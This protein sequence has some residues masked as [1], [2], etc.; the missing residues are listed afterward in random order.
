[1]SFEIAQDD[2]QVLRNAFDQQQIALYLGAGVSAASGL[3]TWDKLILSV[4]FAA[5]SEQKLGNWRP[6]PN[7]LYAISDWY[8]R[9][10][11]EPLEITARKLRLLFDDDESGQQRFLNA[12]RD[13]LYQIENQEGAAPPDVGSNDTLSAVAEFCAAPR[14]DTSGVK[15]VV[16]Y[17][18]DN[19]LERA[20]KERGVIAQP[21]FT[22]SPAADGKLPVFHVHG[23]IPFPESGQPEPSGVVLSEEEYN[24]AASD[25]YSWSNL[26]QLR[27]MSGSVG[28]MVGLS[29]ADRNIRRLL[30]ALARSPVQAK[31]F[32]LLKRPSPI[33]PTASEVDAI[34]DDAK[35]IL[36]R[37]KKAGIKS[38]AQRKGPIGF[39]RS[40]TK[41]EQ[42]YAREI[43]GIVEA[44]DALALDQ[45]TRVLRALG[46]TPIWYDKHK[47]IGK[48][49]E[50]IRN[51]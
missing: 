10:R 36:T 4:Y 38:R 31:I 7:Y 48:I 45:E 22:S 40:A 35:A 23:Y 6:F 49:L 46:I 26:V 30:D 32:A 28:V 37:F 18:Y 21:I 33:L 41:S 25:P 47:E 12:V 2:L 20:L 14:P 51:G 9:A 43:R 39:E 1:M 16:T 5:V 50:R 29:M 3:P 24:E 13:A 19:L 8:L 17:N 27:E 34:D 15:S 11:Q 42:R 44:V